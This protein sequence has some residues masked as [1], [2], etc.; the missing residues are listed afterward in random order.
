[1]Q[2]SMRFF[3]ATLMELLAR[4]SPA[5]RQAEPGCM[6]NTRIAAIPTESSLIDLGRNRAPVHGPS[7]SAVI[8]AYG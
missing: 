3:N 5:S 7:P 1:M 2:E 4:T 6:A 8:G